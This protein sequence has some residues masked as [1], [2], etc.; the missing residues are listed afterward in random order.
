M[1][2]V[3]QLITGLSGP[4]PKPILSQ[5]G[6]RQQGLAPRLTLAMKT[7]ASN[8]ALMCFSQP[9]FSRPSRKLDMEGERISLTRI[10]T[11]L[12]QRRSACGVS[13]H[14]QH[15]THCPLWLQRAH[16]ETMYRHRCHI[17]VRAAVGL[18]GAANVMECSGF[19]SMFS[20]QS[21]LG[22]KSLDSY[23]NHGSYTVGLG[24]NCILAI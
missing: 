6:G 24:L 4:A 12:N 22:N 9:E 1:K 19:R 3:L 18:P 11:Q 7:L 13:R 17:W 2:T 16:V 8:T 23:L 21:Y 14:H 20:L 15:T 10:T 5:R